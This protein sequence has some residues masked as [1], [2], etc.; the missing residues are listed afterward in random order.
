[1]TSTAPFTQGRLLGSKI[2]AALLSV[3]IVVA[4]YWVWNTWTGL[5]SSI[6]IGPHIAAAPGRRRM[7]SSPAEGHR[8]TRPEHRS[9]W[10]TT[11]ATARPKPNWLSS[12]PRPT[13]VTRQHRHDDDLARARQRKSPRRSSRF[14]RDSYVNI[15][16]HG[17]A[18]AERG[19]SRRLQSR[20]RTRGERP[21]TTRRA[22][23][24]TSLVQTLEPLT[25]LMHRS[26]RR[27]RACSA[28]PCAISNAIGGVP[29]GLCTAQK[30]SR[31][32]H[33]S[34]SAAR[35]R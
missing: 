35:G 11:A 6:T 29:V 12:A 28:D 31:L 27:S 10:A 20:S 22:R 34:A 26:L 30:R 23:G 18:E 4:S 1:M 2:L 16:G 17:L 15:P 9:F 19:V 32:G 3:A 8:R 5:T 33:Q 13:A 7:S 24:S 21:S 25:N 14:A